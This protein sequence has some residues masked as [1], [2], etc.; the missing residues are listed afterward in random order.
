MAVQHLVKEGKTKR[1]LIFWQLQLCGGKG[2]VLTV[3]QLPG[4]PRAGVWLS[5]ASPVLPN[6]CLFA[7]AEGSFLLF[8]T[9]CDKR[10]NPSVTLHC[11]ADVP[12]SEDFCGAQW[13][14]LLDLS[15]ARPRGEQS[16][17]C[18]RAEPAASYRAGTGSTASS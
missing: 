1:R 17:G 14:S 9:V 13:W 16:G 18:S 2:E 11:L 10:R 3:A 7:V 6:R 12:R 4:Q 5:N 8:L 15:P